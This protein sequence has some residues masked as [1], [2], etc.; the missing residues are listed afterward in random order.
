METF[1]LIGSSDKGMDRP[2]TVTDQFKKGGTETPALTPDS[3]NDS[4]KEQE[5]SPSSQSIPPK[6]GLY[7]DYISH[8]ENSL[9]S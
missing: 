8:P 4:G 9:F 3:K 6:Q 1:W 2:S 7:Q 5:K